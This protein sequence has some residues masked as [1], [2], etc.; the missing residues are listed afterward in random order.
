MPMRMMLLLHAAAPA[1]TTHSARS[2]APASS[3]HSSAESAS[4]ACLTT[5]PPPPTAAGRAADLLLRDRDSR[6]PDRDARDGMLSAARRPSHAHGSPSST[7]LSPV[8]PRVSPCAQAL[9]RTT[10][11]GHAHGVRHPSPSA[12]LSAGIRQPFLC[13]TL[14]LPVPSALAARCP[15]HLLDE[16]IGAARLCPHGDTFLMHLGRLA[17]MVMHVAQCQTR[18]TRCLQVRSL[19][20]DSPLRSG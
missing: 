4:S 11:S 9:F 19:H 20:D 2:R 3:L 8:C 15:R 6:S 5:P 17:H 1:T 18:A 16:N 14:S 13:L 10:Y 12:T 7:V